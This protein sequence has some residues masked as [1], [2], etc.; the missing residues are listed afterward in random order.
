MSALNYL[1]EDL[2]LLCCSRM[3]GRAESGLFA[4]KTREMAGVQNFQ[5]LGS[6]SMDSRHGLVTHCN[7]SQTILPLVSHNLRFLFRNS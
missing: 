2:E 6:L 7:L 4:F 1:L 5:L 3:L